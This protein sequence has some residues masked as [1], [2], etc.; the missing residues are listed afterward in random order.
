METSMSVPTSPPQ[1]GTCPLLTMKRAY[2]ITLIV[3]T[4]A[5]LLVLGGTSLVVHND[6]IDYFNTA[7]PLYLNGKFDISTFRT[8]GYPLFLALCF[9]TFGVNGVGVMLIQHLLGV[10]TSLC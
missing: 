7:Y 10:I 4:I 3:S 5:H 2:I 6:G 9:W 8:P 1:C